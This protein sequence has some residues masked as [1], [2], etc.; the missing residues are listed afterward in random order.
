M[1]RGRE[2]EG[3]GSDKRRKERSGGDGQE[4]VG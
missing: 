2:R 4:G 3:W 1:E